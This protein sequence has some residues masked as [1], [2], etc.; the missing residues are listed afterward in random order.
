MKA[1]F[2]QSPYNVYQRE[3][4]LVNCT[5]RS[6]VYAPL[7]Q[8]LITLQGFDAHWYLQSA[9]VLY[10]HSQFL[11]YPNELNLQWANSRKERHITL[12]K[13]DTGCRSP[14]WMQP[15]LA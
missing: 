3:L 6:L 10:K 12:H 9:L 1:P 11:N 2:Y 5:E 8:P 7:A 13:V 4:A 15:G 14:D